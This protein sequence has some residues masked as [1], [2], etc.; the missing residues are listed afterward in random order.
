ML[1][2]ATMGENTKGG[3]FAIASETVPVFFNT[4]KRGE[5]VQV[6]KCLPHEHKDWN[7]DS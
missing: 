4:I 2:R 5:L 7:L 6:P 1:L 3:A